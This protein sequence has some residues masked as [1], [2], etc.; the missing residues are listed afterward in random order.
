MALKIVK[1]AKDERIE[2]LKK[3]TTC[4]KY[5]YVCSHL[6]FKYMKRLERAVE[7]KTQS[8]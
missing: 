5:G 3:H 6:T 7:N 1:K 2:E 8:R 4:T